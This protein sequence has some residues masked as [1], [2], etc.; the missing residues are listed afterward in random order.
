MLTT[1]VDLPGEFKGNIPDRNYMNRKY[2]PKKG[3]GQ[4]SA[5]G[6]LS[7]NIIGQGE[8]Q[9]TPIQIIQMTN[10]FATHGSTFEPHLKLNK[11]VKKVSISLKE[12]TWKII[13]Q[14]MFEA[15]NH[16]D[17]TGKIAKNDNFKVAAK[18]KL[19]LLFLL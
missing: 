12:S 9:V 19:Q 17:G 18:K 2:P 8:I 3:I 13:N 16:P 1:N 6:S 10:L 4:W 11:K 5:P 14:G 7:N 15:I